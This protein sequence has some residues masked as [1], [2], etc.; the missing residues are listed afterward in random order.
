MKLILGV[1]VF[2]VSANL[3]ASLENLSKARAA[4]VL[5]DAQERLHSGKTSTFL[6]KKIRETTETF[7]G[8]SNE[9]ALSMLIDEARAALNK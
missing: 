5:N 2:L 9:E 3:S 7:H 1:V 4:I 8:T 6:A